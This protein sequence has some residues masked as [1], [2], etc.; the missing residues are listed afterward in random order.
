MIKVRNIVKTYDQLVLDNV[1]L[2]IEDGSIV[3]LVG[4][5]GAGKSTL[6]N[7]MAGVM[8]P[9]SGEVFYD[10]EPIYENEPVKKDVFLLPDNPFYS[11]NTNPKNLIDL[12]A[13]FY[14]IDK[15]TY[16]KY[17]ADFKI[18]LKKSMYNFSKGMRRQ[19]FMAL[20]LAIKPKYL[21]LDEAFDGL[22]PLARLA[23]KKELLKVQEENNMTVVISS[24]SLRELEDI[25]DSYAL[26][27]G[28]KITSN[29]S[30]TENIETYHKYMIAFDY[31]PHEKNFHVPFIT[32]KKDKRVITVVTRYNYEK[33][34]QLMEPYNPLIIDE[35]NINFEELFTIDVESR[36]G[37]K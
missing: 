34:S 29:G 26:L 7:I 12:Y 23:V 3:G 4:I 35:I 9:N 37:L 18:S 22:D 19:V 17:L 30:I 14:N 31:E 27:D 5:N 36:E 1:C 2:E 28:K 11:I 25:C 6:L 16:Y 33:M 20:A 8:K 10:G 24:H 13:T 15:E 32:F 21:F